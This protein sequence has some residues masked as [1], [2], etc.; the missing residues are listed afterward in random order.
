MT[1]TLK[2][3]TKTLDTNPLR[4]APRSVDRS[5]GSVVCSLI[6]KMGWF[7]D[8]VEPAQKNNGTYS[9]DVNS[10]CVRASVHVCVPACACV[11]DPSL[12]YF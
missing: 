4:Q 6:S 7:L 8:R 10:V 11:C 1:P 2:T 12:F 5:P 9:C 3:K